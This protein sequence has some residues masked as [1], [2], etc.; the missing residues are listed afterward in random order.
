MFGGWQWRTD[1]GDYEPTHH[2]PLPSRR[3]GRPFPPRKVPRA[4]RAPCFYHNTIDGKFYVRKLGVCM[5]WCGCLTHHRIWPSGVVRKLR[6]FR[7]PHGS[8]T[9]GNKQAEKEPS[10]SEMGF[11]VVLNEMGI[12][13]GQKKEGKRVIKMQNTG[14]ARRFIFVGWRLAIE[15]DF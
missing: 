4:L 9:V 1:E 12:Y 2:Q 15:D 13:C 5:N 14:P 6:V 10:C 11:R 3:T 8:R 7:G